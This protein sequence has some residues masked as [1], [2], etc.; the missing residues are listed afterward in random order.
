M[1]DATEACAVARRWGN[2]GHG[3]GGR[4]RR[5]RR[6]RSRGRG[7]R[8]LRAKQA[9]LDGVEKCVLFK[10]LKNLEAHVAR[11]AVG[12]EVQLFQ[13]APTRFSRA[14]ALILRRRGEVGQGGGGGG[15]EG[16]KGGGAI[17]VNVAENSRG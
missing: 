11:V 12:G 1:H 4:R 8:R 16:G 14:E 9:G 6:R 15:V 17:F 13:N 2:A 3:G 5:G 10:P 7:Q